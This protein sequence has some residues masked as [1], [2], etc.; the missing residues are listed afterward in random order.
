MR[1][2]QLLVGLLLLLILP[3]SLQGAAPLVQFELAAAPGFPATG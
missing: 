3:L 1:R 2:R